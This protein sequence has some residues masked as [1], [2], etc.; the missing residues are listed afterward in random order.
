M[1]SAPTEE[2]YLG[3]CKTC[4]GTNE[5]TEVLEQLFEDHHITDIKYKEWVTLPR[6]SLETTVSSSSK[7][8]NECCSR[9]KNLKVHDYIAKCQGNHIKHAKESLKDG[10]FL[11]TCD[12]AE[13]F[14]FVIEDAAPGFHWNNSQVTIYT[15]VIYFRGGHIKVLLYCQITSGK[16]YKIF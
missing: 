9:T 2:C 8:I 1:C 14:A 6:C 10:E 5:L 11:V 16:F 4:P 7:F 15:A 12:F 3:N 13:N